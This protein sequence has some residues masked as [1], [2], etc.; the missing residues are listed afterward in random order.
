MGAEPIRW[1]VGGERHGQLPLFGPEH[2][3]LASVEYL[4][5]VARRIV[6][7]VPERSRMPFRFTINAYRGCRHAC[8][9]CFARPTH[10]YLGMGIG[11]DFE[12]RI[13]VKVNAVERLR[14][15]LADPKWP[16]EEIA[17]GTNTD[18]YQPAEGRYRLTRGLVEVLA[19]RSNPFSILTKSSMIIRDLELLV[20]AAR[21]TEVG[22]ALS[23]GSVDDELA[24]RT[25]PGAAPPSQRL[26]ALAK[27]ADAGLRPSVLV[28]PVLPGLSDSEESL[29]AVARACAEAGARNVVPIVLHLRPGVREHYLQWLAGEHPE[30]LDEHLSRYDGRAY[31]PR[32]DGQRVALVVREEFDRARTRSGSRRSR[33]R[34]SWVT[35]S[36]VPA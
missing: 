19:E 34:R 17:M 25:E 13:V 32:T 14:L 36:S 26:E 6:N 28:A 29:R 7:R 1:E 5:V 24:A 31:L 15:E 20:E 27:L 33:K 9:Y 30:L 21:V 12:R 23:I 10:E 18:P 2:R 8:T 35:T 3:E 22:V 16:G 4:P 11:E